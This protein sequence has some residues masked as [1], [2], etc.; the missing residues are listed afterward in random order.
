MTH[1]VTSMD[2]KRHIATLYVTL[3]RS[4]THANNSSTTAFHVH[5]WREWG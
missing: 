5:V 4:V 3:Y 2:A 1:N